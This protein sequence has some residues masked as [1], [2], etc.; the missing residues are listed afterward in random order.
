MTLKTILSTAIFLISSLISARGADMTSNTEW[1]K[2]TFAGGCFWCMQPFFDNT[3]G[4]KRTTVGYTGGHTA[5][6]GYEDVSSGTTGHAESI[7]IEFDPKEVSYEKLLDIYWHNIDPTKVNG[8]FVDEGTQYRTVIF[9]HSD[10]QKHKAEQ[11]RQALGLSGRFNKPIVTQIVPASAFYPAED[12]HQKYYL[13][14]TSQYNNYHDNSGR[15]E[16]LEK[17]WGKENH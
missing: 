12:Y 4:V 16:Y 8:Q 7:Q 11:S 17:K 1:E 10:E 14:S 13:K 3:K 6:P 15:P 5:N 9:Y 2:A